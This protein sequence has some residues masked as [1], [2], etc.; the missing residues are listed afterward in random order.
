ML[1]PWDFEL[2]LLQNSSSSI[3]SQLTNSIISSIVSGYLPPKS[4]LPGT[5]AL[6]EKLSINRKTVIRAYEDLTEKGWL[7]TEHKRGTFVSDA[8]PSQS[9]ISSNH[10]YKAKLFNQVSQKFLSSTASD[11]HWSD[12]NR[13]Y[14]DHSIVDFAVFSRAARH[15]MISSCRKVNSNELIDSTLVRSALLKMLNIEHGMQVQIDNL[16]TLPNAPISIYFIA[17][18]LIHHDDYVV[19]ETNHHPST[20][21]NFEDITLN[22]VTVK[23]DENGINID[24]LEKLCINFK[25]KLLY[26]TP[27]AQSI[28]GTCLSLE[29]RKKVVL[30]AEKYQFYIIEDESQSGISIERLP[31]S[32]SYLDH[33]K[34]VIY[35]GCVLEGVSTLL[36]L[37]FMIANKNLIRNIEQN[38]PFIKDHNFEIVE[39]AI[40]KLLNSG[41]IKKQ[42]KKAAFIISERKRNLI[43]LISKHLNQ[44]FEVLETQFGRSL[45][46]LLDERIDIL[47][48]N[49]ELIHAKMLIDIHRIKYQSEF[50]HCLKLY[51]LHLNN[52]QQIN[53]IKNLKS[54]LLNQTMISKYA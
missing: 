21:K 38:A 39:R 15:A 26:L 6:A 41:E 20:K 8:I 14:V 54:I 49:K 22:I 34:N 11:K 25:I 51:G 17:K 42:T 31:T 45:T 35:L 29:N 46:I 18:N 12:F 19:L 32:L 4:A 24:D 3:H 1:R 5:R 30:M 52:E 47:K 40:A 43:Q 10:D 33:H 2:N 48:L 50:R 13:F 37:A 23:H 16:Y 53:L 9:K 36:N 28:T 7:Y 27:N 44:H